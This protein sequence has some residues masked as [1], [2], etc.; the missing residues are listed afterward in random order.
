[1][2]D[3]F[4]ESGELGALPYPDPV[5]AGTGIANPAA[6]DWAAVLARGFVDTAQIYLMQRQP[7]VGSQT[8]QQRAQNPRALPWAPGQAQPGVQTQAQPAGN[9]GPLL[10]IGGAVLAAVLLLRK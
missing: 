5:Y 10:L 1:M 2:W 6:S 9:F 7:P 8:Q 4:P 3:N